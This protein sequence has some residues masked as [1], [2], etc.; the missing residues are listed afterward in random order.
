[1]SRV[2]RERVPPQ[3]RFD[4]HDPTAGIGGAAPAASAL[5][6]RLWLAGAAIVGSV[7][8]VVLTVVLR[9]PVALIVVLAVI[10]CTAVVD[11]CVVAT[12]LHRG[13]AG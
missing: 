5:T 9:G 13:E 8:G 12:R 6:L 3:P 10:G 2:R 11:L 4:L 7:V 1:M